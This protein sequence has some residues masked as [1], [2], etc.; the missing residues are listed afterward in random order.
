MSDRGNL[1]NVSV[2]RY[3]SSVGGTQ[4]C[5]I[6]LLFWHGRFKSSSKA[7]MFF[8]FFEFFFFFYWRNVVNSPAKGHH[9]WDTHLEIYTCRVWQ[10][11]H[12]E[13]KAEW[14]RWHC[15]KGHYSTSKLVQENHSPAYNRVVLTL[16][17]VTADINL[18]L[19]KECWIINKL[20]LRSQ[21]EVGWL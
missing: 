15:H 18:L 17:I 11:A 1:Y 20:L 2:R 5:S 19:L 13:T 16:K 6:C 7:R 9:A 12:L 10:T 3:S 8:P 21:S 4:K 14:D